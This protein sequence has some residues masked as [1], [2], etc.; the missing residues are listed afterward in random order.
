MRDHLYVSS[1]TLYK[2][3]KCV[4]TATWK[5]ANFAKNIMKLV[6]NSKIHIR[7]VSKLYLSA[8]TLYCNFWQHH[9]NWRSKDDVKNTLK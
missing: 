4:E 7:A 1:Q 9:D 3:V 8:D 6:T 5:Q 2:Q